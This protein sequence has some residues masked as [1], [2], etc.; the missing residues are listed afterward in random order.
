MRPLHLFTPVRIDYLLRNA[1]HAGPTDKAGR[2]EN[3]E[4]LDIGCGGGLLAEPVARLGAKPY[5]H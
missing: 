3:R 5:R 4:V 1:R 2:L